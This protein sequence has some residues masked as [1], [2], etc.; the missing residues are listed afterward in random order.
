MSSDSTDGDGPMPTVRRVD[1][2]EDLPAPAPDAAFVVV[3]VIISSTTVVRLLEAGAEFVRP[4]AD[5][6]TARA[7]KQEMDAFLV[8]EQGG[9]SVEGFDGSPLPSLVADYPVE[10]RPVGLLSSNGTRAMDRIGH[11]RDIYVGSTVNAA[12]VA[13]A[14]ADH[15]ETWLVAAGRQG[16][17]VG[18]DVAGVD[19][20]AGHLEASPP[21]AADLAATIRE[22][23]TAQWLCEM[24]FEHEVEAL[25]EF[26]STDVVPRLQDGVFVDGA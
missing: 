24:G 17:V 7:F 11:D 3:D 5:A 8:G 9:H 14:I 10:G 1:R 20:I 22:T 15:D 21:D 6:D 2:Q 16:E 26:D 25:C 23:P 12:A 4:F 18:E 19:C 13:E